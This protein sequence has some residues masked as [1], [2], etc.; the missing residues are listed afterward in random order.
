MDNNKPHQV[1]GNIDAVF[2]KDQ[3]SAR[4][5]YFNQ[6]WVDVFFTQSSILKPSDLMLSAPISTTMVAT[7]VL[8]LFY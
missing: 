1:L 2:V 4:S 7:R 3:A 8:S 5:S 6:F